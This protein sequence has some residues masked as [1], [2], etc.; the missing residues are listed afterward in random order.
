MLTLTTPFTRGP[1]VR[2]AQELLK[3]NRFGDF[4]EGDVDGVFDEETAR[5]CVKARFWLGYRDDDLAPL[6][7]SQ[8]AAY[9]EGEDLPSLRRARR[10]SRIALWQ[11]KRLRTKALQI[12]KGEIGVEERPSG[13]NNVKY[14]R[15]FMSNPDGWTEDGPPWCAMFVSWC[16]TKAGWPTDAFRRPSRWASCPQMRDAAVA[17]RHD[18]SVTRRP[19]PGD[20][21]IYDLPPTTPSDSLANH[22]GMFERWLDD[23]RKTFT[24]IEG[25]N[26]GDGRVARVT[27]ERRIVTVFIRV[28][29]DLELPDLPG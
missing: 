8:L 17:G 22:V 28:G 27:R 29:K 9:L 21:A 11:N 2:R 24:A 19:Q 25:N 23:E 4:Y 1:L 6:Y 5:A 3:E 15:W 7:N 10:L 13:S 18:L 16:Y 26:G 20:A 12:A 14:S